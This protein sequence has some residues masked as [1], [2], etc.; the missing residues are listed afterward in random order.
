MPRP[1]GRARPV[2]Q[3]RMPCAPVSSHQRTKLSA[4]RAVG[5]LTP[6]ARPR[7]ADVV[8]SNMAYYICTDIPAAPV[9]GLPGRV[10]VPG[11]RSG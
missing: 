10:T 6:A 8:K 9:P 7:R 3:A 11:R 4:C 2:R 1:S 5:A